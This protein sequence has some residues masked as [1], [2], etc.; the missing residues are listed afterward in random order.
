M[1]FSLTFEISI[2]S[3]VKGV[4]DSDSERGSEG[5]FKF[6]GLNEYL[7]DSLPASTEVGYWKNDLMLDGASGVLR[8]DFSD[9]V[10]LFLYLI[11]SSRPINVIFFDSIF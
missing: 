3:V 2:E 9:T 4:E 8:V 7:S 1:S 10:G 5:N 6:G 11:K